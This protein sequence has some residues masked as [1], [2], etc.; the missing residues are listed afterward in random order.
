[1][2][3]R[4]NV[5]VE[6]IEVGFLAYEKNYISF[7]FRL[8]KAFNFVYILF[9]SLISILQFMAIYPWDSIKWKNAIY[10]N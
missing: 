9:I 10:Q 1:M 5:Q 3:L 4:G 6:N 8:D 2:Y 7:D